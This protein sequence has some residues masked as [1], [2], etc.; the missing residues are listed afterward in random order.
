MKNIIVYKSELQDGI[1]EQIKSSAK[2]LMH[3]VLK[4]SPKTFDITKAN[5]L[6]QAKAEDESE[7]KNVGLKYLDSIMVSSGWNLNDDIFLKEELW[8]ARNTPANKPLNL[9]HIENE[10]VGH[11]V[12]C[13]PVNA[14]LEEIEEESI[15][16]VED[17]PN[18][19]HI[20]DQ[21]VIYTKWSN[22]EKQKL[23]NELLL[24]IDRGL[25]SVSMEAW[26]NNFDYCL[27]NTNSGE[28]KI[29]Q[30]NEATAFLSKY[31]RWYGGSGQYLDSKIG[32]VLRGVEFCGKGIVRTPANPYSAFVNVSANLVYD[33]LNKT[34]SNVMDI[35]L[36]KV[37]LEQKQAALKAAQDELNK[38]KADQ[39]KSDRAKQLVEILKLDSEKASVLAEKVSEVSTENFDALLASLKECLSV[40][41]ASYQTEIDS[42]KAKLAEK[43]DIKSISQEIT[44]IAVAKMIEAVKPIITESFK[45][46][47]IPDAATVVG[48]QTKADTALDNATVNQ[49]SV[50]NVKPED[51]TSAALADYY[52][53]FSKNKK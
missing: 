51:K 2:I 4:S 29:V 47:S 50:V 13:K 26:F 46:G 37:E 25:W 15:S 9:E 19:F 31:L 52:K 17:L 30:R 36:L 8:V 20:L 22:E 35:D 1:S 28:C 3:S 7:E 43:P 24:E 16:S 32:R 14:E 41:A 18:L 53:S 23:I 42:L 12:G 38:I 45:K 33:T 39:L 11:I 34:E 40:L 44:D 21:C 48:P 6:P 5:I 49:D 10:I 27:M